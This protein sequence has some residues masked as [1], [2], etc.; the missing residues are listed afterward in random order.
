MPRLF[1]IF[2]GLSFF[3]PNLHAQEGTM[4]ESERQELLAKSDS[5]FAHGIDL[6][7]SKKYK[8]AIPVFSESDQIDK[9]VLDSTSNRRD[10]SAM[11]LAS[12]YYR[13]GDA[14]QAKELDEMFYMLDPI[15]RRL[16]VESDSLAALGMKF[17]DDERLDEAIPYLV[18][19]A[20]I[21][22]SALGNKSYYY[23][24]SLS[25]IGFY[26]MCLGNLEEACAYLEESAA[27]IESLCGMTHALYLFNAHY[28][29]VAYFNLKKY[30]DAIRCGR[31]LPSLMAREYGEDAPGYHEVLYDLACCYAAMLKPYDLRPLC[32]ELLEHITPE[33]EYYLPTLYLFS[34]SY[35]LDD[36]KEGLRI[37]NRIL[38]LVDKS[39]PNYETY[40]L[41]LSQFKALTGDNDDS[42]WAADA[43]ER[44]A[45]GEDRNTIG[46]VVWQEQNIQKAFNEGRYAEALSSAEE[47]EIICETL[48]GRESIHYIL[49][50][51]N[52][53]LCRWAIKGSKDMLARYCASRALQ[54]YQASGLDNDMLYAKLLW[55]MTEYCAAETLLLGD[56]DL[57]WVAEAEQLY[58]KIYGTESVEY[59]TVL[60]RLAMCLKN[61]KHH[62]E[63]VKAGEETLAVFERVYGKESE[64][65]AVALNNLAVYYNQAGMTDQAARISKKSASLHNK[66]TGKETKGYILTLKNQAEI[67][68]DN[69]N[70][71]S[72]ISLLEKALPLCEEVY[73]SDQKEY[74]DILVILASYYA[75]REDY[76]QAAR[77]CRQA[78]DTYSL[79]YEPDSPDWTGYY[80][81][82]LESLAL[83]SVN[84]EDYQEAL[85][86]LETVLPVWERLF[87]RES[88]RCART[89]SSMAECH[90]MLAQTREAIELQAEVT[91]I[92]GKLDGEDS[93]D[94]LASLHSLAEYY[95]DDGNYPQAIATGEKLA[96]ICLGLYG[97]DDDNYGEALHNLSKYYNNNYNHSKAIA[98]EEQV[99]AIR[100]EVYGTDDP[101]YAASLQSL[102]RYHDDIGNPAKA[103]EL[104]GKAEEIYQ[105]TPGKNFSTYA[106]ALNNLA[107]YYSHCDDYDKAVKLQKEALSITGKVYGENAPLYATCLGN[108]A[109]Y[110]DDA[111]DYDQAIS[112][113]YQ[114]LEIVESNFGRR[115]QEC[116][117]KRS[118]LSVFTSNAG[119]LSEAVKLAEEA[120]DIYREIYGEDSPDCASAMS[121]LSS[122]YRSLGNLPTA[123][124]LASRAIEIR[125]ARLGELHP[126]YVQSLRDIAAIAFSQEDYEKSARLTG[127]A[128]EINETL[129]GR[130]SSKV[131]FDLHNM[132]TIYLRLDRVDHALASAKEALEIMRSLFGKDNPNLM[133][134]LG[135]LADVY[136]LGLG[137]N[138]QALECLKE[139]R[140]LCMKYLGPDHPNLIDLNFRLTNALMATGQHDKAG[141]TATETTELTARVVRETFANLT[142]NERSMFWS[143]T[144]N[145]F[146]YYVHLYTNL[147][148]AGAMVSNAYNC[149]LLSKG[150]LL[151]SEIEFSNLIQE[152]GDS[153]A[154]ALYGD[155]RALRLQINRLREKPIAERSVNVDSLDRIAQDRE[156]ALI[157]RSKVF[158]DYTKNLVITW[159]QVQEKL[160]DKDIAVEFVSFPLDTDS[161]MYI[162]YALRKGW[163][164]PRMIKLFEEKELQAARAS[165]DIYRGDAVSRLVW[166]PL[167]E[168]MQGVENV[169]FAPSGELY[170]IAIESVPSHEDGGQTL[171]GE[172]RDYY[173]LSSTRELALTKDENKWK[174]AAVYGGLQYGMSVAQMI[175][176]DGKYEKRDAATR[177]D[178]S[179]SYYVSQDDRDD[180]D[181]SVS[182]EIQPLDYLEGT[183]EEAIAICDDLKRQS[184]SARLLTDSVGTETSF[185]DLH[186]RKK[187]IIHIGTHGFFNDRRRVYE[188]SGPQPQ[189]LDQQAKVIEDDALTQS[190]LYFAGADNARINGRAAIP[191]SV[192]D[193]K[194]TALEIA[195][196]DLRGLDLVVLSACQTGLG[197]ITGDGV[198][199]LQRGFKK[200][201]AQTIVMSLWKVDDKATTE[202]MTTFFENMKIDRDGHP[203]NKHEAFKE[204]QSKL[205]QDKDKY[206]DPYCW[207]AFVMLD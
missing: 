148:P 185:K 96:E 132:A 206:S 35:A 108:L 176:Q 57:R 126:D 90:D 6:Y 13:L 207:A 31:N 194:L 149:A 113:G 163:E 124:R 128:V 2:I 14:Q 47:L 110:Y 109:S 104:E 20:E 71:K 37:L 39:D 56:D 51:Y 115:H 183:R 120:L 7:N 15:D 74:A 170:N 202:F 76:S 172:R 114:A 89:L 158:G 156:K 153:A 3:L 169:Y 103:L 62:Q 182:N 23:A 43:R 21:E 80:I 28:A 63:A 146:N 173:R 5:L 34:A 181:V 112:L 66:T 140:R 40:M 167:D 151:N 10:Y 16:T 87:D 19:C 106:V 127:E 26:N 105:K 48:T 102:A 175:E 199:G 11:W 122:Y 154:L 77:L 42:A 162:A 166:M 54:A 174:E 25:G 121:N 49:A 59:A 203:L 64:N 46:Y 81:G 188:E 164:C 38:E 192:D 129:Y 67:Q 50:L 78:V 33:H 139:Q 111:C 160:T 125:K 144:D 95:D 69:G 4:S 17:V 135:T 72:A 85:N 116:A 27:I 123:M 53:S 97:D 184:V 193:G 52:Q 99:V 32:E 145:W 84:L 197:E 196:L 91:R 165:G 168:V 130:K 92:Y 157:E 189:G 61:T 131:A 190:G 9:A 101:E 98:L 155:L 201:G 73:G 198:F 86:M 179:P 60:N 30:S 141:Q 117:L 83:Y 93:E 118:N 195:Q 177:S 200:A 178:S 45:R 191:D 152:S 41:S 75:E 79:L 1:I 44:Y 68:K 36:P 205:K 29:V 94:Y 161:T 150:L 100:A 70:I 180:R 137:D 138:E 204:A 65:Y 107:L 55:A 119:R 82:S 22:K 186:G 8:E 147:S 24:T 136:S 88:K 12:C 18:Q 187:S 171:V 133:A 134:Y 58:K 142:A 143:T 159:Q